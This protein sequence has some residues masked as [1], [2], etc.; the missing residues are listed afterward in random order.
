MERIPIKDLTHTPPPTVREKLLP[1]HTDTPVKDI[2][3][4]EWL[5]PIK[6]DVRR[7]PMHV[8]LAMAEMIIIHLPTEVKVEEFALALA[9]S[10]WARDTGP[11]R[12]GEK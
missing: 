10:R 6:S 5:E 2:Q 11:P 9:L 4:G 12:Q 1:L 8:A 7:M 3:E